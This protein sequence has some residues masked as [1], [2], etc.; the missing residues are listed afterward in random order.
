MNKY[1][2]ICAYILRKD[3]TYRL[4]FSILVS[5]FTDCLSILIFFD[6]IPNTLLPIDFNLQ[7]LGF[8]FFHSESLSEELDSILNL[9]LVSYDTVVF[10]LQKHILEFAIDVIGSFIQGGTSFESKLELRNFLLKR[11]RSI[12]GLCSHFFKF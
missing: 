3:Y 9:F 12:R 10:N 1:Y 5:T 11:V 7:L 2:Y 4:S 8:L 6:Y